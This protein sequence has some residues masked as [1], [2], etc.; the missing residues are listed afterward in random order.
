M[1]EISVVVTILTAM[2]TPAILIVACG[3]LSLT[4]SQR[5]SRS[6]DRTR[7]ISQEF[8]EIKAGTKSATDAERQMLYKQL[9]KAAKRAIL[10]Q[11]AMTLLYTALGFFIATSLFIGLFEITK[12]LPP[13]ILI[14]LPM[15][16]ALALL[17]ASIILIFETRLALGAV[18]DEM[19]FR[20]STHVELF[21]KQ[22]ND[23]EVQ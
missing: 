13:W 22:N 6:I 21:A 10:L 7:K 18:D 4:T 1:D 16:G 8:K 19:D 15:I 14:T 23:N 9:I 3:S 20:L 5:L 2:I 11:R 17:S 12:W